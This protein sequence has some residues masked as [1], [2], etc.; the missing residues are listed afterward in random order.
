M[1]SH[2]PTQFYALE[3][4][5]PRA[6]ARIRW[7]DARGPHELA[8]DRQMVLGSADAAAVCI[9]DR[10]VSRAHASLEP[11]DDGVWV[12][13]LASRNGTF[14]GD[15]R[16]ESA[17]LSRSANLRLGAVEISIV[18]SAE[19]TAPQVWPEARYA[20]LSGRTAVM[21][22][23]FADIARYAKTP[24]PVL[25]QGE[26]GTGKELV[27]RA[28]HD[29]SPAREGPFVV[30]DC[31]ALPASLLD[32]ELF[33]H[34]RGA[35]TGADSER[36]GAF[37]AANGGTVF[38]DE[39]GE[40]ALALQPKLLRV[41]ETRTVRR[42]GETAYR[43]VNVRFL[44]ATHRD[45]RAMVAARSF[46]E[47]LYF[48]LA[49][50]H[51]SVPPLRDRRGDIPLLLDLFLSPRSSAELDPAVLATLVDEPWPG[52][53]R[54]LR[55]MAD[56]L[57]ALGLQHARELLEEG[58][59]STQTAAPSSAGPSALALAEPFKTFRERWIEDGERAYVIRA[60][61]EAKGNYARAARTAGVDRT[62]MFRLARKLG[63]G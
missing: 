48:R 22:Q 47:D 60:L 21:R 43:S 8:V 7:V 37:E 55:N 52:N 32:S 49:V 53:V 18:Y 4:P 6:A 58:A 31:G 3:A 59:R 33:G 15:L 5:T 10:T 26:T 11:R 61:A 63:L 42:V 51:L 54:E 45:L 29:S 46:R 35:Y 24:L 50:L 14:I 40:L 13:D 12:R 28:L 9:H 25:V 23:L 56:R 38:L 62:Y 16:V 39:I 30:V 41:L 44:F 2:E 17:R 34:A 27:A 20:E 36:A 1:V 19:L 57:R